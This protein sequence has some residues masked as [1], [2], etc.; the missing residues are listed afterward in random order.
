VLCGTGTKKNIGIFFFASNAS[1][2]Y[3]IHQHRNI[4]I[5]IALNFCGNVQ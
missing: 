1:T 3:G 5:I 4:I 2:H